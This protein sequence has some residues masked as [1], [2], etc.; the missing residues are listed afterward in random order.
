MSELGPL[1]APKV[2]LFSLKACLSIVFPG[3]IPV[4]TFLSESI[5]ENQERNAQYEIFILKEK[6]IKKGEVERQSWGNLL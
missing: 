3:H 2:F 4:L 1:C 6:A 5:I